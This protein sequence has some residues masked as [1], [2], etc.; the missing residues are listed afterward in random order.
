MNGQHDLG[1]VWPM[2]H[3]DIPQVVEKERP[4]VIHPWSQKIFSE[5]PKVGYR[6]WVVDTD[7]QIIAYL[8]Q[9]VRGKNRTS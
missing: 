6:Y 8:D 2:G 5:C 3:S 9:S 1:I 4:I 7:D